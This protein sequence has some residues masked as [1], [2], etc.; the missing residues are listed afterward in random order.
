MHV[1]VGFFNVLAQDKDSASTSLQTRRCNIVHVV[2]LNMGRRIIYYFLSPVQTGVTRSRIFVINM[3]F[4]N[5]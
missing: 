1:K 2:W 3:T 5:V 4:S